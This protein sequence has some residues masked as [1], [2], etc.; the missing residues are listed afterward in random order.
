MKY[1]P[2]KHHRR[3]IRLQRYDYTQMGAYFVTI[4]T[5]QREC[6]FGKVI[7]GEMQLSRYG[8]TVQFNWDTLPKRYSNVDLDAF[9][10]MPNHVHG[11]IILKETGKSKTYGLPEVV[12]GFKTFSARRINQIRCQ[13]GVPVWQR[14]YYEHIIRTEESLTAI[15]NYIINNPLCW[16]KDDLSPN[17]LG[18]WNDSSPLFFESNGKSY[19]QVNVL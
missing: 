17:K 9:I 3:S 8:E 1:A 13:S 5:W 10:I 18:T 15:R 19:T 14:G 16:K 11:I 12:R 4:C 2:N 6:L 7:N